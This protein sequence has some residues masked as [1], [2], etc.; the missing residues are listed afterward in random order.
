MPE[1]L[2]VPIA[3]EALVVNENDFRNTKWSIIHKQYGNL[4]KYE[5]IEPPPFAEGN[6]RPQIGVTL[7]WALPD[8]LTHGKPDAG[9][10]LTFPLIPNRWL[11]LRTGAAGGQSLPVKAWV[12]E[13][14]FQDPDR[15]SNI[16]P[17][18]DGVSTTKLGFSEMLENWTAKNDEPFLTALG[19]ARVNDPTFAAYVGNVE[20]VVSYYDKLEGLAANPA[21]L[22]YMVVGWYA[23]PNVDDPLRS[24]SGTQ[25]LTAWKALL[26]EY[27]WSA[28]PDPVPSEIPDKTL[29]HG[30]VVGV[31]WTGLA[32]APQPFTAGKDSAFQKTPIASRFAW[33]NPDFGN[34]PADA[35]GW[36]DSLTHGLADL[37]QI[38][39]GNSTADA[40]A[41]LMEYL[42]G[43]DDKIDAASALEAMAYHL[44]Q[45]YDE[46]GGQA[47][48]DQKIHQEWFAAVTGET[49][50]EVTAPKPPVAD[51]PQPPGMTEQQ[52]RDKL[53]SIPMDAAP[54]AASAAAALDQLNAKQAQFDAN[55]RELSGLRRDLYSAWWKSKRLA[56]FGS[57]PVSVDQA[58]FSRLATPAADSIAADA[59]VLTALVKAN[60]LQ[61]SQRAGPRFFRPADPVAVIYGIKRSSKHGADGTFSP[62]GT[63]ECRY[64]DQ[65][66]RSLGSV[67]GES[68]FTLPASSLAKLPSA[69]VQDLGREMMLLSPDCASHIAGL[70]NGAL[71][72][73]DVST[74]QAT[75]WSDV[76]Q[77]KVSVADMTATAGFTGV[78]PS[79]LGVD[80]WA[81]PWTPIFM[82]WRVTWYPTPYPPAANPST[83][84]DWS[85]NG[86]DYHWT[87]VSKFE[88]SKAVTLQGKS[89]LA[90]TNTKALQDSLEGLAAL[91]EEADP[92]PA[93]TA[94]LEQLNQRKKARADALDRLKGA[95]ESADLVSQ[96]L[97]GFHDQLLLFDRTEYFEPKGPDATDA[98]VKAALG[99][100]GRAAP[101][102]FRNRPG[103]SRFF[104]VRAG[105][106]RLEQ[107]WIIDAFGQVFDPIQE[108]GQIPASFAPVRGRGMTAEG[109]AQIPVAGVSNPSDPKTVG[110]VPG[111]NGAA[112]A[113]PPLRQRRD[114]QA[115]QLPPRIVQPSRIQFR[116]A[117][118]SAGANPLCGWLLP[119]HFDKSL[120]VYNAGGDALG[121]VIFSGTVASQSIRWEPA[122]GSGAS[123]TRPEDIPDGDLRQLAVSLVGKPN[124]ALALDD[125]LEVID[126]T[127]W[128]VDPLG[129]RPNTAS[130]LIGRPIAV[131]RAML[132][133][134]LLT[135]P[136]QDQFFQLAASESPTRG[137]TEIEF[138]VVLGNTD[139][140]EDGTLGFFS[141]SDYGHFLALHPFQRDHPDYVKQQADGPLT[142]RPTWPGDPAFA[143]KTKFVTLLLDPR[144]AVTARTGLLPAKAIRLPRSFVEQPLEKL[145]VTFRVGPVLNEPATLRMPLPA[146]IRGGWSWIQLSGVE[147]LPAAPITPASQQARLSGTPVH[148]REGWLKLSGAVGQQGQ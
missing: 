58:K 6:N 91:L 75:I 131:V 89:V 21:Q 110:I 112:S 28:T 76:S 78:R 52:I 88:H 56:P 85:F 113:E 144:G 22:T 82:S 57:F 43:F 25:S 72:A 36:A 84:A 108:R 61:L 16:F 47:E 69:T 2:L 83:L 106:F 146:D 45:T 115:V 92:K 71:T 19:G 44:E 124:G 116:F 5:P 129:Q 20:N 74:K 95:L 99:D 12:V 34:S 1:H 29:Y 26:K 73:G 54:G 42:G 31:N 141:G 11:V 59:A 90:S 7:H 10:K 111:V 79:P 121:A 119:N 135:S 86:L 8:A 23:R 137:F 66:V 38:A 136:V 101:L 77:L 132:R 145:E 63:L 46:P 32:G 114:T 120:T 51:G 17:N 55:Q 103:V 40:L 127:L 87:G 138:P 65:T 123:V 107:L 62:G 104:P 96:T 148:I 105:H 130:V 70:S 4:D 125:L 48:L 94:E 15:G 27:G 53:A 133:L 140:P 93:T 35:T 9:G 68:L 39:I 37:P 3:L 50:W 128:T 98:L 139:L 33:R 60:G 100:G 109:L 147:F 18:A 122:L 64:G 134:E 13:S 81:Q 143:P 97:A 80:R 117:R 102:P 49:S 14:D 118:E 24:M 142:L 41:S 126:R 30:M 67:T